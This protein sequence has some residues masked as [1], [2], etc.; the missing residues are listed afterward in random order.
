VRKLKGAKKKSP[1]PSSMPSPLP[2]PFPTAD[3]SSTPSSTPSLTPS[4][5]PSSQ[6]SVCMDEV[7]WVVGGNSMYAGMHCADIATQVDD[8][9][10]VLQNLPDTANFGKSIAEAC[11]DCGGGDHQTIF[12]STSPSESPSTSNAPSMHAFPSSVP[13][14]QPSVCVDEID[15]YFDETEDG[16]KLGC[17]AL[18]AN[19]L[20]LCEQFESFV[21]KAKTVL[22]A[23]CVCGGG[24]HQSVAP[25]ATPTSVPSSE[26]SG[27]PS[28][29]IAPSE[30]PS[31]NP[32]YSP[33]DFPST[34]PSESPSVSIAPSQKPS[35]SFGVA[36]DGDHCNYDR[37]C[38]E[39]ALF[40]T[41]APLLQTRVLKK[42]S[43]TSALPLS[44]ASI[45]VDSPLKMLVDSIERTCLWASKRNSN[46]RCKK[47]GVAS[48]CPLTCISCMSNECADSDKKFILVEN[49]ATKDCAFIAKKPDVRCRE[50]FGVEKT[51]RST[52]EYCI[53]KPSG[54]PTAEPSMQPSLLP[55]PVPSMDPSSQP[56][57]DPSRTPSV[58]PSSSP[59]DRPSTTPSESM[60]P[61]ASPIE[62]PSTS[63][64]AIPTLSSQPSLSPSVTRNEGQCVQNTCV[65][66]VSVNIVYFAVKHL[67]K[68]CCLISLHN[69]TTKFRICRSGLGMGLR[70]NRQM[71]HSK[72]PMVTV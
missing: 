21:H 40:P 22:L 15:W 18:D 50:K 19:P 72:V 12:P 11:C 51:C 2:S 52:C 53:N 43:P 20:K 35:M 44:I 4:L 25:S 59:S 57:G 71:Q 14:S 38:K 49:K 29:S 31:M 47:R 39:R 62:L 68:S 9:C 45:C 33:S 56:S 63:P 42:T 17:K 26:P 27:E 46:A 6:P 66:Q 1:S 32:S 10:E 65:A 13:S 55:S 58:E 24:D 70:N 34:S 69:C 5:T 37:E 64:S 30:E 61:S 41:L 23:C 48:H 8:W 36:F 54:T 16:E 60:V 28:V 7:G 3:P 67:S